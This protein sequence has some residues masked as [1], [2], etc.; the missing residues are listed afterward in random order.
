[1]ISQ[2]IF[3]QTHRIDLEQKPPVSEGHI[4]QEKKRRVEAAWVRSHPISLQILPRTA[5]PSTESGVPVMLNDREKI[6]SA[7]REKPLKIFEVMKRA[8]M[9]NEDA[10]QSLLMKMRTEGLVKFDIHKGRWLIG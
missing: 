9:A 7:L 6:L 3:L 4:S 5:I 8:N 2:Y 1:M 10:C